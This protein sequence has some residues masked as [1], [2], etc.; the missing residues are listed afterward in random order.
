M[1]PPRSDDQPDRRAG[2]G[3]DV[4]RVWARPSTARRHRRVQLHTSHNPQRQTV[5]GPRPGPARSARGTCW[6]RAEALR[7]DLERAVVAYE[8][9][10]TRVITTSRH[11]RQ[12][13]RADF[14]LRGATPGTRPRHPRRLRCLDRSPRSPQTRPAAQG[15]VV[16]SKSHGRGPVPSCQALSSS[17]FTHRIPHRSA[18][19][20][21]GAVKSLVVTTTAMSA[22]WTVKQVPPNR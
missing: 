7:A 12:H 5:P 22:S 4:L 21:A 17:P 6:D 2:A 14:P 19:S 20:R 13:K 11:V 8:A 1:S 15:A 16:T 9:L 18:Y 3:G 10:R